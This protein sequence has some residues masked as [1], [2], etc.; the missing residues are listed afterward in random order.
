LLSLVRDFDI[1]F[2]IETHFDTNILNEDIPI[3]GFCTISRIDRH[4]YGGGVMIYVSDFL[5]IDRRLDMDPTNI[6]C[7]WVEPILLCSVYRPLNA[8]NTFY[9]EKKQTKL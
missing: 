5:H 9:Q 2:F 3:E 4:S 7:I 6:D 8:D 1:L